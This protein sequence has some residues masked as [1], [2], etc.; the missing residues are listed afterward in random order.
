MARVR[1]ARTTR[2]GCVGA[3]RLHWGG[4][5]L[6][7]HVRRGG[8]LVPVPGLRARK[9]RY[10]LPSQPFVP[11]CCAWAAACSCALLLVCL[12]CEGTSWI[13]RVRSLGSPSP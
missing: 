8:V 9:G 7:C 5:E 4:A 3:R 1:D 10:G 2:A 13:E 12:V 11:V 6:R